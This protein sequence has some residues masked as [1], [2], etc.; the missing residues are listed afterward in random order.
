MTDTALYALPETAEC[1]R[2][3]HW[4]ALHGWSEGS[5]GNFSVRLDALPATLASL[6]EGEP[7]PVPMAVPALGRRHLLVSGTGT[8]ARDIAEAPHEGL[9]LFRIAPDGGS[10]TFLAGNDR[11]TSE[12]PSHLAIHAA[13]VETRPE[14]RAIVHTHP[15]RL[16]AATHLSEFEDGGR[17]ADVLLRMQSEALLHLPDGFAV[18]PYHLPGSLELGIASA[19]AVRRCEVVV[20]RYHGALATG[21]SLDAA[22]DTLE[23]LDKTAEIYWIL[24]SAGIT[25]EGIPAAAAE[26]ALRA[27]GRWDR[28]ARW[29]PE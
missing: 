15:P 2:V 27:F 3:A 10:Y 17:M 20:W 4:L 12:M 18:L 29:R 23:Y 14:H 13:L 6:N 21:R 1:Q 5:G 26:Q 16:I 7:R 22:L 9:G 28:Y 19:A 25:P 8:R 11:P 24:R